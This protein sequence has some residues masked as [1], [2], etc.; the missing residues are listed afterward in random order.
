M[1]ED[2]N[3]NIDSTLN[4]FD[5]IQ[6]RQAAVRSTAGCASE[7]LIGC[8]C[9]VNDSTRKRKHVC[10]RWHAQRSGY[11]RVV[12]ERIETHCWRII[13]RNTFY[14]HYLSIVVV[15]NQFRS[16]CRSVGCSAQC[17]VSAHGA[18]EAR[19]LLVVRRVRVVLCVLFVLMFNAN[20][21]QVLPRSVAHESRRTGGDIA[22]CIFVFSFFEFWNFPWFARSWPASLRKRFCCET[23]GG[24][25]Y[26]RYSLP[27]KSFRRCPRVVCCRACSVAHCLALSYVAKDNSILHIVLE[28]VVNRSLNPF[29]YHACNRN[30]QQQ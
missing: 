24:E 6:T 13:V 9:L 28:S 19:R 4:F 20:I 29:G 3:C 22:C 17:G 8:I 21:A 25:N 15:V 12:S 10:R 18:V 5:S 27:L 2:N 7:M 14:R 1:I 11:I 26:I 16:I 23:A 30:R